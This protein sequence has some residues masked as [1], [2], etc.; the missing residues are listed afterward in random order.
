MDRETALDHTLNSFLFFQQHRFH[1]FFSTW[2]SRMPWNRSSLEAHFWWWHLS[3]HQHVGEWDPESIVWN[4]AKWSQNSLIKFRNQYFLQLIITA[5]KITLISC[6]NNETRYLNLG[7]MAATCRFRLLLGPPTL[8]DR[9]LCKMV[10]KI[11]T[12]S[13]LLYLAIS[14]L[15]TRNW[16]ENR[17]KEYRG[18]SFKP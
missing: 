18:D 7:P 4:E 17:Q 8:K 1:Y 9:D 13:A 2:S 14:N 12:W 3:Q 15:C 11:S 6:Y 5:H 16:R 10:V